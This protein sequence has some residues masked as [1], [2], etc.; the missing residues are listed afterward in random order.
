M[1][2]TNKIEMLSEQV[3]LEK[4]REIE[5]LCMEL[6]NYFAELYADDASVVSLWSKTAAEEA[7]HAAQF[8]F[9]LRL[10]KDLRC[11]VVV[12]EA[13]V[14]TVM[15]QFRSCIEK[16]KSTPPKLEDA[17]RFSIRLEQYLAD[18]HFACVAEIGDDSNRKLFNAMMSSDN[19]HIESLQKVYDKLT[20]AQAWTFTD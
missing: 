8:T 19:E 11:T 16:V 18:F 5:L 3:L 20:G 4:C 17:L 12:D 15:L 7:N 1:P 14:D 10:K 2:E 13:L 9:A 6:Y